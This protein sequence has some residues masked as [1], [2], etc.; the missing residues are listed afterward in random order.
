MNV[1]AKGAT[2]ERSIIKVLKQIGY[3]FAA[4]TRVSSRLLDD[5]KIDINFVPFLIQCK[6]GY[7]KNRPK[8]DQLYKEMK[9]EL[10][11][12]IPKESELHTYPYILLH[13]L[14]N[15]KPEHQLFTTTTTFGMELLRIYKLYMD[16]KFRED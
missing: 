3:E 1:R 14:D 2:F 11:K 9:I 5:C 6:M 13:H 7:A 16:G 15:R 12:K 4:S 8:F 10:T